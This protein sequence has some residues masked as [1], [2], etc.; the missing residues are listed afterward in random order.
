[1]CPKQDDVLAGLD[2]ASTV[3]HCI[4]IGGVGV[5]A[6]AEMLVARVALR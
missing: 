2:P 6:I 5:S 1:M 3:I 4:G